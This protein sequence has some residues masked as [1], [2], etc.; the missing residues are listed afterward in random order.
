MAL[1]IILGLK[2]VVF[3]LKFRCIY[4]ISVFHSYFFKLKQGEF[5][6][7]K[8]EFHKEISLWENYLKQVRN[9]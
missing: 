2:H 8:D 5:Q 3:S 7:K 4:R 1:Y 6:A 9:N